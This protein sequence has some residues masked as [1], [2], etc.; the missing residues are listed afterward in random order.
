MLDAQTTVM[1]A[2]VKEDVFVKMPPGFEIADK[3]N[4]P[5]VVTLTKSLYVLPLRTKNRLTKL[6]HHLSKLG[7]RPLEWDSSIYVFNDDT[8]LQL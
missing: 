6:D 5:L 3:S 1:N 4:L 7:L 8:G 2:D